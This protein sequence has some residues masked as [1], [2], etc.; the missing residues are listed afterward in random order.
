MMNKFYLLVVIQLLLPAILFSQ[1]QQPD[2]LQDHEKTAIDYLV[3][4]KSYYAKST[5][6]AI[7]YSTI[8]LELALKTQNDSL[9]AQCYKAV[10]VANYYAG[11]S[12]KSLEMLDSAMRYFEMTQNQQEISNTY[13]NRGINFASLGKYN[14]AIKSY[15]EALQIHIQLKDSMR[16]AHINNNIGSLYYQL[17]SF[18]E[19]LPYFESAYELAEKSND[20]STM[21]SALN[22]WGLVEKSLKNYDKAMAVFRK[23]VSIGKHNKD[24]VGTANS[25]HN[26]GLIHYLQNRQDSA[27]I[28]FNKAA[29]LYDQ[30]GMLSG[31]NHLG[32]GNC[33]YDEG[34]YDKATEQFQKA[35]NISYKTN[36]RLLRL[37]ALRNLY[38]TWL[39]IGMRDRAFE[40]VIHYHDLFDSIKNLFDSTAVQNLQARF[41][42]NDKIQEVDHLLKEK[43]AQEKLLDQQKRQLYLQ[44]ILL[45]VSFL[46]LLIV[47]VL[48]FMLFRLNNKIRLTN[49]DLQQNNLALGEAK[50]ALSLSHQSLSEQ[51]ELLRTLIN[52]TP[53]FIC[54]KNGR[55]QWLQ[56]NDALISLYGLKDVDYRF[57]TDQELIGHKPEYHDTLES[58]VLSDEITW[59][60]GTITRSDEQIEAANGEWMIFDVIK[61]PLFNADGSRKGLI[62]LGRDISI[63][64]Q[65]ERK[66]EYALK[67]AEESDRL[68]TAFLSNMSH[69]IRTPLNA[70]IGFS[71]LLDEDDL[72]KEEKNRFIK[73]IHE[74]GNT[75][76]N[77]I[78]DIIDLA[79][80]EAGEVKINLDKCNITALFQNLHDNYLGMMQKRSITQI[81]LQ[82]SVPD[83]PI[84]M[85]TDQLKLKQILTNLIDNALKFTEEGT[86]LFGFVVN[87]N[88]LQ[89]PETIQIFVKDTGVGIPQDKQGAVFERFIKINDGGKKL[90]PG[91]GLGLSIVS[92]FVH[93]MKG[94]IRL[95]SQEGAGSNFIIT[96]PYQSQQQLV[97][98]KS[99]PGKKHDYIGKTLLIVEDVDSNFELLKILL[100]PTGAQIMRAS[101]GMSAIESC[102]NNAHI[103][104]VLMDIQLPGLNGYEATR[105]IK[106]IMPE[107]PIIAQTAFAMTEEKNACFDAGCDAYL[108]K[109]IRSELLFPVIDE[110]I[111][112]EE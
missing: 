17:E 69:E 105:K 21:M 38:E 94:N 33:Y 111:F 67:K 1:E 106:A 65:T 22:N 88:Q 10:G 92:Q 43:A 93:L 47:I 87:K 35:L 20:S 79:R 102:Q 55:G 25:W 77:L 12:E 57:K 32:I 44:R 95:E 75:L 112:A 23:S 71:D 89:Q 26:I 99:G 34:K 109:P 107:L 58:N 73:L 6:K 5:E 61:V 9:K 13:N 84:T 7:N 49:R 74:N 14:Q 62:V 68:K 91:T 104:L 98:E 50:A 27:L 31:N 70:I 108:A 37:D 76:L 100:E 63:R 45:I 56:A 78:G 64:K 54:F 4:A 18:N 103:N 19:A 53:D 85:F 39:H 66:L 28:Y 72:T 41:E 90:Y 3:L 46:S 59:Q 48:I 83:K 36:D 52:A 24:I 51:E 42:V 86:I 82:L 81:D 15:T 11:Q 8:A 60:K 96:L 40:A 16:I 2:P 110:L 30:T 29:V 97:Q 80:I 101:N